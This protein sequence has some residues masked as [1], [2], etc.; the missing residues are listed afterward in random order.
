MFRCGGKRCGEAAEGR[1]QQKRGQSDVSS[2]LPGQGIIVL[3]PVFL[4]LFCLFSSDGGL[5]AK[6]LLLQV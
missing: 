5:E 1:Y 4:S 2:L 6:H 3:G